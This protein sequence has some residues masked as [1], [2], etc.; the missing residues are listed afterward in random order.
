MATIQPTLVLHS[1]YI[2]LGLSFQPP[3]LL[4]LSNAP[5]LTSFPTPEELEATEAVEEILREHGSY[6]DGQELEKRKEVG[7][8]CFT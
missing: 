1:N 7:H 3:S 5:C 6:E 2:L 4:R 8:G